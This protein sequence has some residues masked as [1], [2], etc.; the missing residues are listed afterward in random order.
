MEGEDEDG[1]PGSH[2]ERRKRGGG[3]QVEA[4]A[5]VVRIEEGLGQEGFL[6]NPVG[7]GKQKD[8]SPAPAR[9]SRRLADEQRRPSI[10]RRENGQNAQM[11]DRHV[12]EQ[13]L[14]HQGCGKEQSRGRKQARRSRDGRGRGTRRLN[15]TGCR[16]MHGFSGADGIVPA[17]YP[18]H[19]MR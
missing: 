18:S 9:S 15:E 11:R 2:A 5:E 3:E 14:G 19:A 16:V 6:E 10:E 7:E 1:I 13:E 17:R 12:A 8:T 4:L